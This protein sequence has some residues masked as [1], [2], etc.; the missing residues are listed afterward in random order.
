MIAWKWVEIDEE[1]DE[2]KRDAGYV[3]NDNETLSTES[4]L[5][6][7]QAEEVSTVTFKCIGVKHEQSYQDALKI[8]CEL[9]NDGETVPVKLSP[10]PTNPFDS[11]A[12]AF[13]CQIRGKWI[14]IGYVVKEVCESVLSALASDCIISTEFAWVKFKILRT[15][16]PGYYAAIDITRKGQWPTIV[17]QAANT[18][19]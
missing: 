3:E 8:A 5:E 7:E 6:D 1:E 9:M 13:Q 16:G 17:K 19:Y 14:S 11:R 12:I 18:M 15:T 2:D 4:D 10:E